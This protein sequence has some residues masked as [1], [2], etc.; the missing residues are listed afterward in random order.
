MPRTERIS[1]SKSKAKV[2]TREDAIVEL[3][4]EEVQGDQTAGAH[5]VELLLRLASC[6]WFFR[7]T[8]GSFHTRVPVG[9]RNEV[10][11]LK[12]IAFRNWLVDRYLNKYQTL[13]PQRSMRRVLKALEAHARFK[14]DT[15]SVYVHLGRNYEDDGSA[16]YVDLGDSSGRAVKICASGWTVEDRPSVDF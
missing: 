1:S 12:S 2:S 14:V 10:I 7:L 8:D 9:D 15:P 16:E 6:A 5:S 4:S 3:T 11:R 13:P